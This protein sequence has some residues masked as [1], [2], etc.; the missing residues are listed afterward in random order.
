MFLLETEAKI[1]ENTLRWTS[2]AINGTRIGSRGYLATAGMKQSALYS[3]ALMMGFGLGPDVKTVDD[4]INHIFRNGWKE[5]P[6]DVKTTIACEYFQLELINVRT[7]L[8][9]ECIKQLR[10]VQKIL[11]S[12]RDKKLEE[13]IKYI[14]QMYDE[15]DNS[16][17]KRLAAIPA[18]KNEH[19]AKIEAKK[20]D[21]SIEISHKNAIDSAFRILTLKLHPDKGGDAE[22]FKMLQEM[23]DHLPY[24]DIDDRT[25]EI[26]SNRT[27]SISKIQVYAEQDFQSVRKLLQ[28]KPIPKSWAWNEKSIKKMA[29]DGVDTIALFEEGGIIGDIAVARRGSKTPKPSKQ[30]TTKE[31]ETL[32][33]CIQCDAELKPTAKFCGSCGTRVS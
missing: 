3:L 25:L 31:K 12:T 24:A 17:E 5:K 32:E 29:D 7:S 21:H 2:W 8:V 6:T 26:I 33:F 15:N 10:E 22:H 18:F 9:E 27:V 4:L 13:A 11:F 28:G 19:V 1:I 16:F 14:D 20:T 30:K 23:R